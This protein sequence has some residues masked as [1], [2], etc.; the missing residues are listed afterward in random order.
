MKTKS[1]RFQIN[2]IKIAAV[3]VLAVSSSL[4]AVFYIGASRVVVELSDEITDRIAEQVIQLSDNFLGR[5][6]TATRMVAGYVEDLIGDDH[7][8][9]PHHQAIWKE[10]WQFLLAIPSLQ[11]FFVADTQGSY[12]QVRRE[13]RYATRIIDRAV[14]EPIEHWNFRNLDY[15]IVDTKTRV[16]TFDPRGRPWYLGT[17]TEPTNYWSPVYVF[18][19][20]QT[21]GISVTYPVLNSRGELA[22][23][24]CANTPLHALSSFVA[25]Q[26][27]SANGVAFIVNQDQELIAYPDASKTTVRD[28][29]SGELR[30]AHIDD[31]KIPWVA[32]AYRAFKRSGKLRNLYRVDGVSYVGTVVPFPGAYGDRWHLVVALPE[33]DI[34]A[35]VRRLFWISLSV[36]LAIALVSLGAVY[37]MSRVISY[38][39]EQ[40]TGEM[41][42]ISAFELDRVKP[43]PSHIREI[44]IMDD[45]L[46]SSA[47]AIK[48]FAKY[49]PATLVRDLI[50]SGEE[51]RIGGRSAVLTILFSDVEGFTGI[52]EHTPSDELMIH[53]SDYFDH[54]THIV[55]EE[56]GTIDKYIGDSLMAFWGR[57]VPLEDA[58]ERACRA[59]LLCAEALRELNQRWGEEGKP[60][61]KTRFGIHTGMVTVGNMGSQ[62]RINYSVVGDSVNVASRVEGLNRTYGTEVLISASTYNLVRERFLCRLL[63]RVKVKGRSEAIDV[64]ELVADRERGVTPEQ[65]RLCELFTSALAACDNSDFETA[66][67]H[68]DA[69]AELAPDDGPSRLLRERCTAR[70][71]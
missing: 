49:V 19:T 5:S 42:H 61:M 41:A 29:V 14:S 48:S 69:I 57:P 1:E 68:L 64:Y 45:A 60:I 37:F 2:I 67:S 38:Q 32:E 28:P 63:D 24:V 54:L 8:A 33:S 30:M 7:G 25:R 71:T 20:A 52:A 36:G 47:A 51:I 17:G 26:K 39:I 56:R 34:L 21:P 44:Q 70:M 10:L 31:L 53:L 43:V 12:V 13:P 23:V 62:E 16:P 65:E 59:G 58:P 50:E 18:T 40:L 46:R 15:E 55:R 66:L 3:L 9:I 11:S 22:A 4:L 35:S 27:V 6:A